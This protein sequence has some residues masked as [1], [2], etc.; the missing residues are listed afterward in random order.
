[1]STGPT[2]PRPWPLDKKGKPKRR[3][4]LPDDNGIYWCPDGTLE[5][6]Y[7]DADGRQR[8]RKVNGGITAAR[9]QLRATQTARDSGERESANPRLKFGEAAD[10]WL[11]EQVVELRPSTRANYA[12]AIKHHLRRWGT[13]A[14]TR[15]TSPTRRAWCASYAPPVSPSGRSP[16]SCGP[17]AACSRFARRHCRWRGENPFELLDSSERPKPSATPQRRIY[18]ADELAQT[19]AA[20][21][22]P[23]STLFRLASITAG[24]EGELLGL[25]W[26][27]LG[28]ADVNAATIRFAYQVDHQGQRVALKT[29]ESKAVLPLPRA[30]ALMLQQHE[31][32]TKAQTGPRR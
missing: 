1:M 29:D 11:A 3:V 2:P 30:A 7:R 19:I 4:A 15:S 26:E 18:S 12:G 23:W 24:R 6:G 31:A 14:W 21:T 32:Q 25:W 27:D 10:R 28:L 13:A 17:A 20:S 22:E 9:A 5:I 16:G 8:W